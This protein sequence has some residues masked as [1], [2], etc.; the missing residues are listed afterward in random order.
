MDIK[1][2]V[3]GRVS[4]N[5]YLVA[6]E[7]QCIIVDPG[8]DFERI[9]HEIEKNEY[10]P[11][12]IFLTHG[13]FDH[14]M[15]VNELRERFH[16]SVYAAKTEDELLKSE[17]LNSSVDFGYSYSTKAD[18]LL[19][20]GQWI[21]AIGMGIKVVY[22][23]GHTAGSCCYYFKDEKV[24]FSGDTLF[25]SS[26]GRTDLPTGD[27]MDLFDS[28]DLLMKLPEDVRVFCGHGPETSIGF[29]K[30]NNPYIRG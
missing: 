22:T 1:R 18:V 11:V 29:E 5:C 30:K 24:L 3:V 20:D 10:T 19:K 13:H 15:A 6:N 17:Y 2:I 16:I 25:R 14:I 8:D 27:E 23:P 28:L 26:I 21:D 7:K 9:V 4:T 12:A